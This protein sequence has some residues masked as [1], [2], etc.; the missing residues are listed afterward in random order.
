M[1]RHP[2]S[3]ERKAF[4]LAMVIVV[5]AAA[6]VAQEAA[7]PVATAAGIAPA[8]ALRTFQLAKPADLLIQE[9]AGP[10]PTTPPRPPTAT[11]SLRTM[12]G[13][14]YVQ[15]ADWGSEI[16]AGGAIGGTQ[17]QLN[18]LIT[19]G[20]EGLRFDHGSLS[21]FDPDARWRVEAGDVY[22]QLR[23]ASA[24]GRVSWAAPGNRRPAIAIYGPRRGTP[25]RATVVSYRDQVQLR[26][27]TLL[28]AEVASD[29]S[30]L[31]R[32][33]L[34]V[35]HLDLEA[36]Y[37]SQRAPVASRDASLSGGLTLWRGLGVA[38]GVFGS[39][40]AGER[41]DWRMVSVR[42]PVARF[43][44][45]TLERAF[46]G[47]RDS[48]STT[49]AV[50]GSLTA[51]NLRL[52]HRFQQ[53][54]YDFARNGFAGTLERQQT[55]SMSSYSRGPRLN[56][57][58]QLATQ[59]TETGQVQHWEELQTTLKLSRTT[60]VRAVTAVPDLRR[61]DRLQ[62]YLRQDLPYRLALQADYGRIS[63]FQSIPRELDR[64][65]LKVM[66]FKTLD[67]ATPAR[68]AE[69]S[70]RVLDYAG[71]GV[72]GARVKLGPYSVDS[73][74]QGGY[75]FKHVPRGQFDL[76]LDQTLLPAD[77]AWDGK[78]QRVTVTGARAL[79]ADLRVTPLNAIHGR[80]YVDRNQ[81]SHFDA[82][83]AVGGVVI[84]IGDHF[85]ATDGGGSYSFYNLW[86]ASY[87]IRLHSAPAEFQI[88]SE[89]RTV[90]LLDGA[91][92]TGADFRL[93]ET[94]KPIVWESRS[95]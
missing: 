31:L 52:F 85:T 51:G 14:G 69:V 94:V 84:R 42:V 89:E 35:S 70:G 72:A 7:P 29:K 46:A 49:S 76:S 80:V 73:D 58:L 43:L 57:T 40:Q 25:A 77:F 81:N 24:G 1:N 68:G 48:S 63:A 61:R 4:C 9:A 13:V 93:R 62:A 19:S 90:T 27:Q 37:R 83:E 2:R 59:R 21:L 55:Q 64:S 38:G 75:V 53:G 47:T 10:T 86:P 34:G 60:T 71:R 26:G 74:R 67:I 12:I 87:V 30:Y 41:S 66:L 15:G 3:A 88:A 28:D 50:M 45:L 20:R 8:T 22:S 54:E 18:T 6:P 5:A 65:R 33:R 91:P 23:G 36:F 11:E 44:D 32:S 17:V 39:V 95:R 16:M 82:G 92:V 78:G 56:L 79:W